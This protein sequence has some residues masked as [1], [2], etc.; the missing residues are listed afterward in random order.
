MSMGHD[1]NRLKRSLCDFEWHYGISAQNQ[2]KYHSEI[3]I[4]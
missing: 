4:S 2:L 3:N 1:K